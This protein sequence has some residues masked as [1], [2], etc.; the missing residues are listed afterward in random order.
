MIRRAPGRN[1]LLWTALVLMFLLAAA[2]L[3]RGRSSLIQSWWEGL[4][5]S[6]GEAV[7]SWFEQL[8]DNRLR[9]RSP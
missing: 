5:V 3:A 1:G 9:S 6:R 4:R 2:D 8:R 7:G